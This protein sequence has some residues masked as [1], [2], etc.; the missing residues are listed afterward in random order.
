MRHL[1]IS[2][3]K[4]E[5]SFWQ[6]IILLVSLCITFSKAKEGTIVTMYVYVKYY[7]F[8]FLSEKHSAHSI[9]CILIYSCIWMHGCFL[10]LNKNPIATL[11]LLNTN[12]R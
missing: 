1:Y 7:A 5:Q 6:N 10:T 11:M 4:M 12:I 9:N 8:V 2:L 3:N